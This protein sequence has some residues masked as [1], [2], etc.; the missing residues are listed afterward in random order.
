[1]AD[2]GQ[3]PVEAGGNDTATPIVTPTSTPAGVPTLPDAEKT[4][5]SQAATI[6]ARLTGTATETPTQ[7]ATRTVT[8]SATPVAWATAINDELSRALM[9]KGIIEN[10]VG[11]F[12]LHDKN[13]GSQSQTQTQSQ[14]QT[15]QGAIVVP[16]N[17]VVLQPSQPQNERGGKRD[18]DNG[19]SDTF[20]L[21]DKINTETAA[22]VDEIKAATARAVPP[23]ATPGPKQ[24]EDVRVINK[25]GEPVPVSEQNWPWLGFG[26]LITGST[27]GAAA[28]LTG[29]G[30][31]YRRRER[32]VAWV[33]R[34]TAP[35]GRA[36]GRGRGAG[37]GGA[38]GAGTG[39]TP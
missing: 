15:G 33:H 8:P 5:V 19:L 34:H 10:G 6:V 24:P 37:A 22:R 27:V 7:T 38:A 3:R 12:N 39:G 14:S 4:T 25:P 16:P 2:Q 17:V 21:V 11:V 1:M 28:V 31:L 18:K 36:R 30:V 9:V 29:A 26:L 32:L 35:R 13:V 20:R 23:T